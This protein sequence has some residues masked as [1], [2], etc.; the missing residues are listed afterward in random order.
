MLWLDLFVWNK[1]NWR[2]S[3]LDLND[4]VSG[5]WGQMAWDPRV[6]AGISWFENL[7]H[8]RTWHVNTLCLIWE[9]KRKLKRPVASPIDYLYIYRFIYI[10]V[11]IDLYIY[12][13]YLTLVCFE[14]SIPDQSCV[15]FDNITV[16]IIQCFSVTAPSIALFASWALGKSKPAWMCIRL[17]A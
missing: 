17:T 3:V 2:E 12:L 11:Y 9:L 13:Y 7:S 1:G 6:S 14:I 4:C 5:D 10:C 8:K 16:T 15:N